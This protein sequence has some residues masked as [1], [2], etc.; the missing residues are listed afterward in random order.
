MLDFTYVHCT[1]DP[2][3][4]GAMESH[5]NNIIH[6]NLLVGPAVE[7]TSSGPGGF[8]NWTQNMTYLPM[9]VGENHAYSNTQDLSSDDDTTS[10]QFFN[11]SYQ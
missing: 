3:A 10:H 5:H 9:V 11:R 6:S 4:Q 1:D 2:V 8:N 7:A